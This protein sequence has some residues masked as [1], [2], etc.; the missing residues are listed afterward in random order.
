[1]HELRIH[2]E[3]KENQ[4]ILIGKRYKKFTDII[5][6]SAVLLN[7]KKYYLLS[8]GAE[9]KNI[10]KYLR[11]WKDYFLSQ[12]YIS[13]KTDFFLILQPKRKNCNT[14]DVAT[15]IRIQL[16]IRSSIR[17]ICKNEK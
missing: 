3:C 17:E 13:V 4:W 8:F 14:L 5:L 9:S 15:G 1:M 10:L 11:L 6:D 7:F 16:S 2:A 12:L